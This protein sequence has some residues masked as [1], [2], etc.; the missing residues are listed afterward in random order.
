ML[1][2]QTFLWLNKAAIMFLFSDSS[3]DVLLCCGLAASPE[4]KWPEQ[5][6]I[7]FNYSDIQPSQG[8]E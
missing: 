3:R 4:E 8:A 1:S 2:R 5:G 6:R 7:L